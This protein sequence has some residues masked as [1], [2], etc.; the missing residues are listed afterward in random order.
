MET[1]SV[2]KTLC[3]LMFFIMR[4]MDKVQKNPNNFESYTSSPE[5]FIIANTSELN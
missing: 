2:S 1:G 3:S 5:P 4:M